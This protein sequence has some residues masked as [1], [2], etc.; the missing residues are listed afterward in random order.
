MMI[1]LD[2]TNT[3]KSL[4][5]NSSGELLTAGGGGGGAGGATEATLATRASE[6]TLAT[7]ASETTL[8]SRATEATLAALN[9]KFA[10][11]VASRV[12][13][14]AVYQPGVARQLAAGAASAS[15]TLTASCRKVRLHARG[16][17]VRYAIGAAAT[18]TSHYLAAGDTIEIGV[19]ASA[20]LHAIR[21]GAVDSTLEITEYV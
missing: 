5:V 6:A 19:P 3:L 21:G 12:Q 1:A 10:A 9:A 16:D 20:A 18:A 14:D 15:V 2:P 4:R 11:L 8:A 7:R 13:V 17:H